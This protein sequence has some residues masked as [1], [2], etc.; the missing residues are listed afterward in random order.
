MFCLHLYE[1]NVYHSKQDNGTEN[2]L[3][4]CEISEPEFLFNYTL[5]TKENFLSNKYLRTESF[6]KSHSNESA[7]FS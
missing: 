5:M 3:L 6:L 4:V 7:N 2:R 1:N